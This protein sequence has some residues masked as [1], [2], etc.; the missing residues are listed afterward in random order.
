MSK[1]TTKLTQFKIIERA[2]YLFL[3]DHKGELVDVE[4]LNRVINDLTRT[5]EALVGG[6]TQQRQ[7]LAQVEAGSVERA[8]QDAHLVYPFNQPFKAIN[9]ALRGVYFL[10]VRQK[11]E[12]VKIGRTRNLS[13]RAAQV[14]KCALAFGI[15]KPELIPVGFIH[16]AHELIVERYLHKLFDEHLAYFEEW[17]NRLPVEQWLRSNADKPTIEYQAVNERQ[18]RAETHSPLSNMAKVFEL[19]REKQPLSGSEISQQLQIDGRSVRR[20]VR[21]L[22]EAGVP[23]VVTRGKYGAYSLAPN[24]AESVSAEILN[25]YKISA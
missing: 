10:S 21:R 3:R 18:K 6:L 14:R 17:F 19:I 5:K 11:P 12:I 4:T 1:S 20:Y 9:T 7:L 24:Y 22:R 25:L 23:V 13:S 2:D 16:T 15:E 8:F